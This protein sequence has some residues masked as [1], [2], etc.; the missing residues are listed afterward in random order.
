MVATLFFNIFLSFLF[1]NIFVYLYMFKVILTLTIN[2]FILGL[3]KIG[4]KITDKL[5]HKHLYD[6]K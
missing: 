5:N 2:L 6:K 4:C 1:Q 3:Y